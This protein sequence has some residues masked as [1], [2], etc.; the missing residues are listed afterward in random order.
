MDDVV[1]EAPRDD[2]LGLRADAT[3]DQCVAMDRRILRTRCVVERDVLCQTQRSATRVATINRL[4]DN[5]RLEK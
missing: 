1:V 5:N 3:A 2:R 4:I